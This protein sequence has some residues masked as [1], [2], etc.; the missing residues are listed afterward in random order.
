MPHHFII[1]GNINDR[2]LLHFD[3]ASKPRPCKPFLLCHLSA[4]VNYMYVVTLKTFIFKNITFVLHW[5]DLIL[6]VLIPQSAS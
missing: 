6:P 5:I 4:K 1:K 2:D 3:Q